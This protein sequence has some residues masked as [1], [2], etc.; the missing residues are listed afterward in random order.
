MSNIRE[1]AALAGVSPATVSRVINHDTV[2]KMTDETRER[3]WKAIAELNYKAPT[4]STEQTMRVQK[5]IQ[6]GRNGYRLGCILNV[7]GGKYSDPYYLS[8][9]SGFEEV[10]SKNGHEIAFIHTN[11]ELGDK[12]LLNKS[13]ETP[14]DG[15]IIMNTLDEDTFSYISKQTHNIVG[16]DTKHES[17][18]N[19]RY[20]HYDA[21]YLAVKH[22]YECG[23]KRIG[24]IGGREKDIPSC[25][26]FKGYYSTLNE[27]GLE[28]NKDWILA[29]NWDENYCHD[30]V[31][32][33][34]KQGTLPDAYFVAS[35]L[36]AIAVLRAFYEL[37]ISVPKECAV[38]GLS[39]IEI[40]KYATPPLSTISIP[41]DEMGSVA[42]KI[43]T[44]RIAGDTSPIK[45]VTLGLS[46]IKRS[47][48]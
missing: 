39:N 30:A 4:S 2:Y 31:V 5:S 46:T 38:M 33:A 20:D 7:R 23:Y 43:L 21:A 9:L 37:G 16:V 42:A 28:Y 32:E 24:F 36:M 48:T 22:L 8:V 13:F 17:I 1:V 40:S 3:V 25:R 35:D 47:S 15:L 44:D 10:I 27:L 19:I 11:D 6:A 29:S 45:T 41:S 14:V 18:D 34:Y 12:Q 26:R